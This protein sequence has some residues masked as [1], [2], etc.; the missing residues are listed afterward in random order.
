[1]KRF[2]NERFALDSGEPEFQGGMSDVFKAYDLHQKCECAI[3][4]FKDTFPDDRVL[5]EAFNREQRSLFDLNPHPNIVRLI[6]HGIDEETGRNYIALEWIDTTLKD[7]VR[8]HPLQNWN[9]FYSQYGSSILNAL[10]FAFSRGILHRD[11]SPGNMLLKNDGTIKVADF[12]ISKF[13]R[14]LCQSVTL[15]E[16]KT[17]PYAPP[18][19]YSDYPDTRDVFSFVVT[20]LECISDTDFETTENAR[21]YLEN[22]LLCSD[23]VHEVLQRALDEQPESRPFNIQ[24]LLDQLSAANMAASIKRP[25]DSIIGLNIPA[26]VANV[27]SEFSLIDE[28]LAVRQAILSDLNGGICIREPDTPQ[29]AFDQ[30]SEQPTYMLIGTDYSY[31][32]HRDREE[33]GFL[34][35]VSCMSLDPNRSEILQRDAVPVNAA[36]SLSSNV[37]SES[38][39]A[40]IDEMILAYSHQRQEQQRVR[41]KEQRE[42]LIDVWT[43][44]LAVRQEIERKQQDPIRYSGI[45]SQGS[46]ILVT[47]ERGVNVDTH[48]I[49]QLRQIKCGQEV[50]ASGEVEAASPEEIVLLCEGVFDEEGLPD[51]GILIQDTIRSQIALNRQNVALESVRTR[52]SVRSDLKN[53]LLNPHN[54]SPPHPEAVQFLQDDLDEDKRDAITSALGT[55]D[56]LAVEGPPGTGKTKLISELVLQFLLSGCRVLLSSQTHIALD[57]ALEKIAAMAQSEG[58]NH[59]IVRIGRKDDSRIAPTAKTFLVEKGVSAWLMDVRSKADKGLKEWAAAAGVQLD[60]IKIG[61]AFSRLRAH[62]STRNELRE[63]LERL[64]QKQDEFNTKINSLNREGTLTLKAS[65]FRSD[66]DL[67]TRRINEAKTLLKNADQDVA[68]SYESLETFPEIGKEIFRISEDELPEFESLFLGNSDAAAQC[69]A[70]IDLVEDWKLHLAG[71]REFQSAYLGTADVVSGT[72]VGIASGFLTELEFDV[73]IVDEASKALPTELLVP[74]VRCRRWIIVGDTKQLSP[75]IGDFESHKDL[76]ERFELSLKDLRRTVLDHLVDKLPRSN[77]KKLTHQYRMAKP[78]GDLVSNCFYGSQLES[79]VNF[80]ERHFVTTNAVPAPV[81]WFCTGA[82]EERNETPARGSYKNLAEARSARDLLERLGASAA[83]VKK[84]YSVVVM[85]GYLAQVRELERSLGHLSGQL[86][87]LDITFC[88]VDTYQ[89]R[90]ADIAVYSVTRSNRERSIGF[91]QERQRI[92]VALSRGKQLLCIIGDSKFCREIV[93]ENPFSDVIEYIVNDPSSQVVTL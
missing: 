78:I 24:D 62:L 80:T 23:E 45:S 31:Y 53:L 41:M 15:A 3:K 75:Y 20:A 68:A 14:Q 64:E 12:G 71:Q 26:S 55:E 47:P 4:L 50:F 48:I 16:F 70:L 40:G 9:D 1:M 60:D 32:A 52:T 25:A 29:G 86:Q 59:R 21:N 87:Y 69:K 73:C 13:R 35:L 67:T 77:L 88:T 18:E 91:L 92:N 7:Y 33:P 54:V 46:R 61:Q 66:L 6:D 37:D 63:E 30:E 83:K 58:L 36:F 27:V 81:T 2:L 17:Y 11:V 84:T 51:S 28:P 39:S 49:G 38:S 19:I 93:G 43:N 79:E 76:C 42:H 85:S 44:S 22:G 34:V 74:M 5:H 10:C 56:L 57:N 65:N 82:L 90:E 89:G 72:C 8:K